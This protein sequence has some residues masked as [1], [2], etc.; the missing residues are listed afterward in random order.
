MAGRS[1][2]LVVFE[3]ELTNCAELRFHDCAAAIVQM[4]A[5]WDV[6]TSSILGFSWSFGEIYC[7]ILQCDCIWL[8]WMESFQKLRNIKHCVRTIICGTM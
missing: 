7:L 1:L 4:M 3:Y 8:T 5:L 2:S 6:M